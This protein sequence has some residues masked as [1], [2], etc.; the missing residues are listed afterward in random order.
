M[1]IFFNNRISYWV[2]MKQEKCLTKQSK[3]LR[4]LSSLFLSGAFLGSSLLGCASHSHAEKES[5]TKWPFSFPEKAVVQRDVRRMSVDHGLLPCYF[6]APICVE[7]SNQTGE[8]AGLSAPVPEMNGPLE[9]QVQQAC[10]E[11]DNDLQDIADTVVEHSKEAG[12][13][14]KANEYFSCALKTNIFKNKLPFILLFAGLGAYFIARRR[15]EIKDLIQF[16]V[17]LPELSRPGITEKDAY[18]LLQKY[19][20]EIPA[21]IASILSKQFINTFPDRNAVSKLELL[22]LGNTVKN[23]F[24]CGNYEL[25]TS[26]C[27]IL[28]NYNRAVLEFDD[29]I[30]TVKDSNSKTGYSFADPASEQ[31]KIWL[32]ALN[33]THSDGNKI[34]E[35]SK[36]YV[37]LL[38]RA[39]DFV[40][41]EKDYDAVLCLEEAVLLNP[42]RSEAYFCLATLYTNACRH[43]DA[44]AVLNELIAAH[45]CKPVLSSAYL[46]RAELC[47]NNGDYDA[48]LHDLEKV[49][50]ADI[51]KYRLKKSCYSACGIEAPAKEKVVNFLKKA[52]FCYI[53]PGLA[54]YA[55][56][57]KMKPNTSL[58]TPVEEKL[59]LL[60]IANFHMEKNNLD[61]AIAAF[62]GLLDRSSSDK[63]RTGL[64][65][66]RAEL[67]EFVND[68]YG[69]AK[70]YCAAL[71]IADRQMKEIA[72]NCIEHIKP[73]LSSFER[74]KLYLFN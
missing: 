15:N 71:K 68:N 24:N 38:S 18:E 56:K 29:L 9:F 22:I 52:Y 61:L 4:R 72:T 20:G 10:A 59:Y 21:G 45:P 62:G 7:T 50:D 31:I 5:A 16:I 12:L 66:L 63:E 19:D 69:A 70:D 47:A 17:S 33:N 13:M 67:K 23:V 54:Y 2:G 8:D 40:A 35:Y 53:K 73:M 34:C 41:K 64:L 74:L 65:G 46:R 25:Y 3:K 36:E 43:N 44:L 1:I 26:L 6:S 37:S 28:I 57:K 55:S 42:F 11:A 39:D 58:S 30:K 14:S 48:A 60:R 49:N 32:N 27:N 51:A